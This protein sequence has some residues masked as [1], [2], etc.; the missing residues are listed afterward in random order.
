MGF[1]SERPEPVA[2]FKKIIGYAVHYNILFKCCMLYESKIKPILKVYS[3]GERRG[4]VF[5]YLL[6]AGII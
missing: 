4:M 3:K 2:A 6:R 1:Y 5:C